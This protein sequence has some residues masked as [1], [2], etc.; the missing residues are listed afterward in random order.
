[1]GKPTFL[2]FFFFLFILASCN[3]K[4]TQ[5]KDAEKLVNDIKEN[6]DKYTQDDWDK[7]DTLIVQLEN[8]LVKN[9]EYYTPEQIENANKTIGRYKV[10]KFKNG[11]NGLKNSMEDMGQQINGAMEELA[12]STSSK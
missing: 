1:M 9:R 12:D 11:L 6:F 10:L 7:V 8:D 2:I 4:E 3:N 5:I